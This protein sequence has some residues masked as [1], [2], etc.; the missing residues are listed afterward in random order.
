M[1]QRDGPFAPGVAR[2]LV[3]VAAQR[4]VLNTSG[5]MV[6]TYLPALARGFGLSVTAM[7]WV[8][9]ARDLT[10]LAGLGLGRLVDR[11]GPW[12]TMVGAGLGA[13]VGLA[14]TLAGPVGVV[15]G[16]VLW[17]L[18]RTGYLVAVNSWIAGVVAYERRG[19]ATGLVELTWAAAALVGLPVMGVLISTLGWWA[20][21]LVLAAAGPPLA[22]WAAATPVPDRRAVPAAG[23]GPVSDARWGSTPSLVAL[24]LPTVAAQF[25]FFVHGLWLERTYGF[26]PAQVGF[27]V[28]AVGTAEACASTASSRLTDVVGKRRAVLAGVAMLTVGV[29]ALAV[30]PAPPLAWGLGLLALSFLGFEFAI[31]SSIPLVS[32]LDPADRSTVLGRWVGISTVG[33]AATSAAAAWLFTVGGFRASMAAAATVAVVS[34][35]AVAVLVPEP[36]SSPIGGPASD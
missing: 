5:R 33:R 21:P 36:G 20:A 25:L 22:L 10:G 34:L 28:V 14:L 1:Q 24:T 11:W 9:F 23:P 35:A 8:V 32:E 18:F 7:G 4:L 15:V 27:A 13:A 6:F 30:V 12:R 19:R 29:T 16:F 17:G 26:D 31:V 2:A 3:P